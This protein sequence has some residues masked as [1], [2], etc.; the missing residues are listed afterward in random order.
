MSSSLSEEIIQEEPPYMTFIRSITAVDIEVRA[1]EK[2]VDC[3]KV[4]TENSILDRE[5]IDPRIPVP[6]EYDDA[7]VR[8][9][10]TLITNKVRLDKHPINIEVNGKIIHTVPSRYINDSLKPAAD[11]FHYFALPPEDGTQNTMET[12]ELDIDRQVL[13][14]YNLQAEDTYEKAKES[15]P[16][17]SFRSC[18][19]REMYTHNWKVYNKDFIVG[20]RDMKGIGMSM[21]S[22]SVDMRILTVLKQLYPERNE[23]ML[24]KDY[25]YLVALH[26]LDSNSKFA[27]TVNEQIHSAV[28]QNAIGIIQDC[29]SIS[30]LN[31]T[32]M[33]ATK[34]VLDKLVL[35]KF[36]TINP[37]NIMR[38]MHI[39]KLAFICGSTNETIVKD[40]ADIDSIIRNKLSS[41]A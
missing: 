28:V 5:V 34:D 30:S 39:F 20:H 8:P 2:V 35:T 15:N 33:N 7:T 4:T 24:R 6:P 32:I 21:S 38:N 10:A 3:S 13:S 27:S 31:T 40:M 19:P 9:Y 11:R 1:L 14:A 12:F 29:T 22:S 17:A 23:A 26:G 41:F 25:E 37:N 16:F 36:S 18:I